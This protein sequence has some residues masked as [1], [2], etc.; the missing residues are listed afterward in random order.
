MADAGQTK[1]YKVTITANSS[2]DQD[3]SIR[4]VRIHVYTTS[5]TVHVLFDQSDDATAD[6]FLLNS[7]TESVFEVSSRRVS[8]YNDAGTSSTVFVSLEY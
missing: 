2:N 6:D 1:S 8:F 7:E 5:S 3:F 4:P